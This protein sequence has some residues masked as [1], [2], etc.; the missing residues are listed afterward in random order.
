MV[1]AADLVQFAAFNVHAATLDLNVAQQQLSEAVAAEAAAGPGGA[2]PELT[3]TIA[4]LRAQVQV[5]RGLITLYRDYQSFAVKMMGDD[6]K[7]VFQGSDQL[8]G[9]PS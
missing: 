6:N 1:Q 8:S 4:A 5:I 3:A 2:P 9:V 7:A